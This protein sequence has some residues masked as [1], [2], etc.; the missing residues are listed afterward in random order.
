MNTNL[1]QNPFGITKLISRSV[2]VTV[3]VIL[4]A[5][6]F[7][8][9]VPNAG[10]KT[11]KTPEKISQ[12]DKIFL[13][14][15]AQINMTEIALGKYAAQNGKLASVQAFGRRLSTDHMVLSNKLGL[16]AQQ[17]AVHLPDKLD[18]KHQKL[19]DKLMKLKGSDFDHAFA[20]AMIDGHKEAIKTFKAEAGKTSDK[21]IKKYAVKSIPVLQKHL[22]SAQDL[23]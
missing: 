6:A 17:K 11:S 9:A 1:S 5:M 16:L 19:A 4:L 14:T 12:A 7:L 15:A 18:A 21:D 2:A 13:K 10:A 22:K 8:F 20:A 3:G 23:K